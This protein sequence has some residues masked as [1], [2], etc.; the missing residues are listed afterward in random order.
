MVFTS[1]RVSHAKICGVL[2]I[3]FVVYLSCFLLN[4]AQHISVLH[5]CLSAIMF[6]ITK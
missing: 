5:M 4:L 2:C 3:E 6:R 1:L